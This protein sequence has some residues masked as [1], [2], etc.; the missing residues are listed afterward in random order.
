MKSRKEK[1]T[2][3]LRPALK[4]KFRPSEFRPRIDEICREKLDD[5]VTFDNTL[6]QELGQEIATE[7]KQE[8]K[9]LGKDPNYRFCVSSIVGEKKGQGVQAG[10]NCA[11]DLDTDS[12]TS[13]CYSSEILFCFVLIF[14]TYRYPTMDKE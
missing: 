7:I 4:D 14:T 13:H 8:L 11:W 2:Y 1:N 10:T 12:C 5:L 6:A 9:D 3:K